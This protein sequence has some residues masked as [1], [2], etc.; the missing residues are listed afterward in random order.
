MA[1]IYGAPSPLQDLKPAPMFEAPVTISHHKKLRMAAAEKL[2]VIFSP[3]H[4]GIT[5]FAVL[6]KNRDVYVYKP[7][8]SPKF[9]RPFN[10]SLQ[11]D[12]IYSCGGNL[13][14]RDGSHM[15]VYTCDED[16]N[17]TR[18]S[19]VE[20]VGHAA[21]FNNC[22]DGN[23]VSW[24]NN[25]VTVYNNHGTISAEFKLSRSGVF[26]GLRS[27]V[28]FGAFW[29]S[30]KYTIMTSQPCTV[31]SGNAAV[32]FPA[33]KNNCKIVP[34]YRVQAKRSENARLL[35][36]QITAAARRGL[37]AE[38]EARMRQTL[39]HEVCIEQ[40]NE[41][42]LTGF[43]RKNVGVHDHMHYI[44]KF[45]DDTE[46]RPIAR[47][48]VDYASMRA[49][50][51]SADHEKYVQDL[52]RQ[53]G[54][55]ISDVEDYEET[56]GYDDARK[57]VK[58]TMNVTANLADGSEL[59]A[60]DILSQIPDGCAE[61]EPD[62]YEQKLAE[63]FADDDEYEP[64]VRPKDDFYS[65][66]RRPTEIC[67]CMTPIQTY[68]IAEL[69]GKL[70]MPVDRENEQKRCVLG[71]YSDPVILP[72]MPEEITDKIA[73]ADQTMLERNLPRHYSV[74]YGDVGI[75]LFTERVLI[76]DNGGSIYFLTEQTYT[77]ARK[78]VTG[79]RFGCIP[80]W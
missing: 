74:Q 15:H 62:E 11:A 5:A 78:T 64:K 10:K 21:V 37:P 68:E 70:N 4:A 76:Y 50:A 28:N 46:T 7:D 14:L 17:L 29:N 53:K 39:L 55:R 19:S 33:V 71:Q 56:P 58:S 61:Y 25:C 38:L 65:Y 54:K 6:C 35:D 31:L 1:A 32:Q 45:M 22:V 79:V 20:F 57:N 12:D 60:D 26:V 9:V 24:F 52:L 41:A 3:V 67:S 48:P 40:I 2:V 73:E 66:Q 77:K 30:T 23:I 36:M 69:M 44:K 75:G 16:C 63:M 18:I 49:A 34:S 43:A 47:R 59:T 42:G 51:K 72:P 80:I 8:P 27:K 13:Y